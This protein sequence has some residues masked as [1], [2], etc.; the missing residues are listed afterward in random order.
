M[1]EG[2]TFLLY[3]FYKYKKNKN[4]KYYDIY[5]FSL[6]IYLYESINFFLLP[7]VNVSQKIKNDL[8]NTHL[9]I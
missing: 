3:C 1:T 8:I 2:K 7:E 9:L 4:Y 6:L 5:Y